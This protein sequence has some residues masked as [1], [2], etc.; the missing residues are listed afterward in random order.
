MNSLMIIGFCVYLAIV[1]KWQFSIKKRNKFYQKII[2]EKIDS[3]KEGKETQPLERHELEL[4]KHDNIYS[5]IVSLVII[6]VFVL[7]K[8]AKADLPVFLYWFW[9]LEFFFITFFNFYNIKFYKLI[10]RLSE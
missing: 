1:W 6:S 2:R 4:M 9:W 7:F 3:L 8:L 10:K 5:T